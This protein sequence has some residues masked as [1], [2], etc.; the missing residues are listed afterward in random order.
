MQ[1]DTAESG[2]QCL[3]LTA[4][5]HYDA[6]FMD[7]MMPE[8]DGVECFRKLREQPGGMCRNTPVV[9]LTAN[10]DG[11]NR[12]LYKKAGF[13]AYL[14]KP[15]DGTALEDTLQSLL[16]K[17]LM[18]GNEAA[19]VAYG[20]DAVVR[21]IRRKA[22]IMITTDSVADLPEELIRNMNIRV[23]PYRVITGDGI[24]DDGTEARGEAVLRYL[25]DDRVT[26][27]SESPERS[28][29]EEFFAKQLSD[30]QYI[31]HVSMA[32]RSSKGF[33]NASEAALAF[34][35]VRVVDSGHLSSGMGLMVMEAVK[36]AE[37]GNRDIKE[38]G[39]NLSEIRDLVQTSFIVDNTEYLSK[40]GRLS[41]WVHKLCSALMI[42]PVIVMKDSAMTVGGVVFG[43]GERAR[44]KYIHKALRRAGGID[45]DALFITYAGLQPDE[46]KLI[47]EE[48]ESIMHFEHVY[49]QPAS[50]AIAINCGPGSF[51]LIYRRRKSHEG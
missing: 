30:A 17:E 46:L 47:R 28:D 20:S 15:V 6:I 2:D 13:D 9:I 33:A 51:G 36:E 19:G 37:R 44:K 25:A 22:P 50:P 41:M 40:S 32:K 5:N 23:I 11:E 31:L 26:A 10:A 45:S 21:Q 7:H 27:R 12:A 48:A 3:K 14:L 16:P 38:L 42:H 8:M 24:F 1:I 39:R 4:Q 49:I 35:N 18:T 29:Y 43:N 34:Y